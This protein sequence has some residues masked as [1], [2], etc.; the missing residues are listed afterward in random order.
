MLRGF[1]VELAFKVGRL[2]HSADSWGRIR[3]WQIQVAAK[4]GAT[5]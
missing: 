5:K 1:F 2:C 4:H 3:A